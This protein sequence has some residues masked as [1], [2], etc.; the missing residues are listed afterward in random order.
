MSYIYA[1]FDR[2][3]KYPPVDTRSTLSVYVMYVGMCG[4][5]G[6]VIFVLKGKPKY[7][8]RRSTDNMDPKLA[9]AS[10]KA[11]GSLSNYP[12]GDGKWWRV[13]RGG[14]LGNFM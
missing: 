11:D 14:G 12:I 10:Q 7:G 9:S 3:Y 8:L 1:P 5:M 2:Y 6:G 4:W 13:Y